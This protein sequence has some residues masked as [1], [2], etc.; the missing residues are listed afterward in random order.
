MDCMFARYIQRETKKRAEKRK[1]KCE[2]SRTTKISGDSKTGDNDC[3][4]KTSAKNALKETNSIPLTKLKK[5]EVKKKR[6]SERQEADLRKGTRLDKHADEDS[7]I[8]SYRKRGENQLKYRIVYAEKPNQM[9]ID[10]DF[11]KISLK[12]TGNKRTSSRKRVSDSGHLKVKDCGLK[13][14]KNNINDEDILNID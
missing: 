12:H 3:F 14:K 5:C 10:L 13:R 8:R 4:A 2:S 7:I 1:F 9:K 11:R 6:I